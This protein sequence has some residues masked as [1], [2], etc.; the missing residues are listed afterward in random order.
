MKNTVSFFTRIVQHAHLLL[1][2][3]KL[4][5]IIVQC[6]YGTDLDM[7]KINGILVQCL[8]NTDLASTRPVK[9]TAERLECDGKLLCGWPQV[10][11]QFCQHR[12][13]SVLHE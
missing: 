12:P 7:A 9:E 8:F 11:H 13:H 10:G 4:N 1:N 3:A 6:L 5:G 2:M